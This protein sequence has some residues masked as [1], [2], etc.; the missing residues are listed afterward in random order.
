MVRELHHRVKNTLATVQAIMGSTARSSDSIEDFKTALIGRIGALAKTHA[1][2]PQPRRRRRRLGAR[3]MI[4]HPAYPVEPWALRETE[5]DLDVL[6]QTE[7]L[8]AL[9]NG[10]IGLR[11]NLDEG[12]PSGSPAPTSTASTS[13]ARCPTPR[14]ATATPRPGRRWSTSPTARSSGCWSTTSRSTCATASCAATS[15]C[16]TSAPACC[17][18]AWSGSSPA[19]RPVRV[20]SVRLVSLVQRAVAADPLRGR[21]ARRA[22]PAGGAVRAGGQR[23]DAGGRARPARGR[24]LARRCARSSSQTTTPAPCSCTHTNGAGCGWPPRWITSSRARREP[25]PRPRAARTSGALTI[26]ADVGAGAAAAGRQAAGLRVVEPALDG[27]AARPGRRP[28]WRRRATPAGTGC[29][30]PSAS[31]STTSG[32]APTSS[33][34]ATPDSSRRSASRSFT[35]CRRARGASG[36]RSRP[37]A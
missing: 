27:G 10:H 37:R 29:S 31:T 21:A 16:S 19:G 26:T 33:S 13:C 12:E 36:A 6:D 28:R 1:R 15:G 4:T 32:S 34:T 9:A 24:G 20:T 22:C 25:R 35:R 17:D 30:T 5:L 8:F 2:H 18:A 23:A 3:G 14:P 7:S 11:G